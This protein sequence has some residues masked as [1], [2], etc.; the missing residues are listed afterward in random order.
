[1]KHLIWMSYV[2]VAM[3]ANADARTWTSSDG[4]KTI[5]A[6]F[7]GSQGDSVTLLKKGKEVTFPLVKLSEG[8]REWIIQE[9]ERL[10]QVEAEKK[11]ELAKIEVIE[12]DDFESDFKSAMKKAKAR[13]GILLIKGGSPG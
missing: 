1:M 6:D 2:G 3:L 13:G 8:D 4:S 7:V 11:A 10:A 12:S 9:L 5:E